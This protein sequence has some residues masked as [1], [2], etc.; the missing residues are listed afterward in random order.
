MKTKLFTSILLALALAVSLA[1]C[2]GNGEE[3]VEQ[4][5][6]VEP[7]ASAPAGPAS[8][9]DEPM[10]EAADPGAANNGILGDWAI[11]SA[12]VAGTS[13]SADEL[14]EMASSLGDLG[15]VFS[16]QLS[17]RDDGTGTLSFSG[18]DLS[19]DFT[20]EGDGATFTMSGLDN[21]VSD[22]SYDPASD[23]ISFDSSGTELVMAR[24]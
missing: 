15:Q 23:T 22:I 8:T 11:D 6:E 16:M 12:V 19:E 7:S 10:D 17:F 5:A 14:T 4:T 13:Y 9:A 2:G 18:L 1:A 24:A 20:W 3:M 21:G